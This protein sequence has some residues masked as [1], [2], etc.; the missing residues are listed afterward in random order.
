LKHTRATLLLLADVKVRVVNERLGHSKIQV[1]LDTYQ[2]VLPTMQE[3]VA[4]VIGALFAQSAAKAA[5]S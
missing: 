4:Q 1:T 3:K 2:H 5:V